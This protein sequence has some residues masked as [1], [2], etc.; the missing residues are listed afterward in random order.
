MYTK[1]VKP[2]ILGY[3]TEPLPVGMV[4]PKMT[5]GCNLF[6]VLKALKFM[7]ITLVGKWS[8]FYFATSLPLDMP[9]PGHHMMCLL[10][11]E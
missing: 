10:V 7:N 1:D 4:I 8:E 3:F 5:K 9:Y 2:T 11:C 6:M